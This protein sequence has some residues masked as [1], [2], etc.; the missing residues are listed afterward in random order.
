MTAACVAGLGRRF[1]L[2]CR[3]AAIAAV[4]PER[5]QP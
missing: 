5:A 2:L 3:P 1:A 4:E